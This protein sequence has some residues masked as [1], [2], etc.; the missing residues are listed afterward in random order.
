MYIDHLLGETKY[1]PCSGGYRLNLGEKVWVPAGDTAYIR[2]RGP[3]GTRAGA[4]FL[5]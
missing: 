1:N 2:T 5:R 3:S 4:L